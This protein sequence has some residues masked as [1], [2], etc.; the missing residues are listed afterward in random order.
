[1]DRAGQLYQDA[2]ETLELALAAQDPEQRLMLISVA[3]CIRDHA[4][5]RF[6][7]PTDPWPPAGARAQPG[8]KDL[9]PVAADR[10]PRPL[11]ATARG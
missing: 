6:S 8:S 1:M 4:R 7:R 2:L 11:C 5:D 9:H 10:I 3:Q